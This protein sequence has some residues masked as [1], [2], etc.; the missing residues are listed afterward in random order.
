M[1]INFFIIRVLILFDLL[2]ITVKT[3]KVDPKTFQVDLKAMERAINK[4]TIMV[5]SYHISGFLI[6]IRT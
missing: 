1:L 6:V 5:C 3:V 4:N 2:G